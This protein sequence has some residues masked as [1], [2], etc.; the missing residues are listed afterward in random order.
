MAEDVLEAGTEDVTL[1]TPLDEGASDDLEAGAGDGS[2]QDGY[3]GGGGSEDDS[4]AAVIEGANGTLKLS[5]K[6]K[7]TLDTIKSTNP[8][9]AKQMR[10]ALFD[11]TTLRNAVPGGVPAVKELLTTMEEYGGADGIA[12]MKTT[13]GEWDALDQDF[14]NADPKFVTDIAASNPDALVKLGPAFFAELNKLNPVGHSSYVAQIFR[15]DMAK[16][17]I[18]MTMRL[19][20]KEL[21]DKPEALKM[22]NTLAG[23]IDRISDL[24]DKPLVPEGKEKPGGGVDERLGS[25]EQREQALVTREWSGERTKIEN[26]LLDK[27]I[28]KLAGGR[29]V[30]EKQMMAIKELYGSRLRRV[31]NSDKSHK[32]KVDRFMGAKDKN[33]YVR[34]MKSVYTQQVPKALRAA[35]DAILP[36]KPGA[37]KPTATAKPTGKPG[38]QQQAGIT[39][40][41]VKPARDTVNYGAMTQ[42]HIR[43]GKYLLKTGKWV[44]YTR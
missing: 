31:L 13:L 40:V 21:A 24:S 6:A 8:L 22:W 16:Y 43:A 18:P 9:L 30:S 35:F 23:Y 3:E 17:D 29:K 36:G 41:S 19:M 28:A 11:A 5:V 26:A 33:G 32:D 15:A 7:A 12:T 38:S 4:G 27:E 14:R 42:Q 1:D 44:Q 25:V 10:A 2:E 20:Q 39:R 37:K 34:H